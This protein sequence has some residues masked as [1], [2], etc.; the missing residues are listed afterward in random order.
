MKLKLFFRLIVG[1]LLISVFQLSAQERMIQGVVTTFDSI[2]VIGAEVQVKSSKQVVKTDTLGR[3]T[4]LVSGK[5]KLKITAR[6]FM[7]SSVKLEDN[8]KVVA[9]NIKLKSGDKAREY[10]IGYGYVKDVDK[11]NA[12]AQLSSKDMDFS[13]YTSMHELIRGRFAGVQ[14][15]GN[16]DIIIRGANSINLSNAALIVVDGIPVDGSTLNSMVPSDVSSINV[17]K[18]GSAA[19]YGSRGANGVV[20]IETKKGGE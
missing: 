3:F 18:D 12:V 19:I 17:L 6:G 11:L 16:G 4:I 10:V 14:V 1:F 2:V 8:T 5:D 9:V 7:S 13:M 20:L 15:Q